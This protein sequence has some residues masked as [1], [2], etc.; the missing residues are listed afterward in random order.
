MAYRRRR[1][2]SYRRR[3][4]IGRRI[5]RTARRWNRRAGRAVDFAFPGLRKRKGYWA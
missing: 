1:R 2:S 4:T 3:P 5:K